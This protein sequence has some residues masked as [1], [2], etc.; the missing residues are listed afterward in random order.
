MKKLGKEK[1]EELNKVW[2]S[3]ALSD[4]IRRMLIYYDPMDLI[5]MGAPD[6]EY[7]ADTYKIQKMILQGGVTLE[8]LSQ[9]IFNLYKADNDTEKMKK[10]S[11]RMAEDLLELK[12]N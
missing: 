1:I 7:D 4:F 11:L 12:V 5:V 3:E 2:Q 8:Q 6:D 10:K 9:S